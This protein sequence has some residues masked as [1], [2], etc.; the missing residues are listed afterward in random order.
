MMQLVIRNGRLAV[1]G[2][3]PVLAA[4]AWTAIGVVL[5]RT[6]TLR[7]RTFWIASAAVVAAPLIWFAY[8]ALLFGD[9]LNFARGPYSAAAIEL[10][11]SSPGGGPP[12]PGWHNPWV[13]LLF[14]VKCA[15]RH[16]GRCSR[17]YN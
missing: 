9:W 14:F 8:N 2:N 15:A 17:I 16:T 12:H 11:T 6:S 4:L 7:S 1:P 3:A 10:R 5:L 13:S